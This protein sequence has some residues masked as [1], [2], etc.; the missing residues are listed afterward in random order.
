MCYKCFFTLLTDAFANQAVQFC[1]L[2][3]GGF[4]I[5]FVT[6]FNGRY[7]LFNIGVAHSMFLGDVGAGGARPYNT[8]GAL[9]DF[10]FAAVREIWDALTNDE[11]LDAFE[12]WRVFVANCYTEACTAFV[13]ANYPFIC[14]AYSAGKEAV[15]ALVS[16]WREAHEDISPIYDWAYA[17][18]L[19]RQ[20]TH[21][22]LHHAA[23]PVV[24]AEGIHAYH[25][26]LG[27]ASSLGITDGS[28]P[29]GAITREQT[30]TMIHRFAKLMVEDKA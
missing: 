20:T 25:K 18:T 14:N 29:K 8:G 10:D 12:E 5:F 21:L 15:D 7:D 22:I 17:L 3:I 16:A 23:A 13:D 19:R 2:S 28:A 30:V 1:Q 26:S 9:T 6:A 24:R 4:S 27:W 11:Q